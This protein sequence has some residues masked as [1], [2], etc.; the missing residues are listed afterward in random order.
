V[1]KKRRE[2]TIE[3]ER[4]LFVSRRQSHPIHRCDRCGE[5][6]LMLTVDEAAAWSRSTSRT[7][8]KLVEAGRLHFTE[9]PDGRLL[10]CF[11]SLA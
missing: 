6:V 4:I 2:V 1:G 3:T 10:I 8:F 7:I 9:T 5:E 11:N